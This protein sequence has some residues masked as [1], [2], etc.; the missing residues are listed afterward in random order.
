MLLAWWFLRSRCF[1]K[2]LQ[3]GR[4]SLFWTVDW[5]GYSRRLFNLSLVRDISFSFET[6]TRPWVVVRWLN[7]GLLPV[8]LVWRVPS[9]ARCFCAI[10][11]ILRTEISRADPRVDFIY[12]IL[13]D[14]MRALF[15]RD[16]PSYGLIL[17]DS[18]GAWTVWQANRAFRM[19]NHQ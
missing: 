2:A 16:R 9:L 15:L 8:L 10:W 3:L 12:L 5:H 17:L 18:F 14:E 11:G 1:V 13:Y 4:R 19:G 6:A 7:R